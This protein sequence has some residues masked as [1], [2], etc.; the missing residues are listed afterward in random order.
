MNDESTELLREIR[1]L[2]RENSKRDTER[3]D[4][5]QRNATRDK[6]TVFLILIPI[7]LILTA[8]AVWT[9]ISSMNGQDG[10]AK[11]AAGQIPSN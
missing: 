10:D 5:L 2:L 9:F 8:F 4:W 3:M 11:P 6:R 1:D 7:F